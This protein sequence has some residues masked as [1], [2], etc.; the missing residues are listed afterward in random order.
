MI[1]EVIQ[2]YGGNVTTAGV[3]SF[4]SKNGDE[5]NS[6]HVSYDDGGLSPTQKLAL[7]EALEKRDGPFL[8]VPTVKMN[9]PHL[10]KSER[11]DRPRS[12]K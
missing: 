3:R 5:T 2:S 12:R 10:R 11:S 6:V 1:T 7:I 9:A 8:R 4:R